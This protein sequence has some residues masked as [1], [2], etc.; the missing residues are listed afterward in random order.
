M[1]TIER[2]K[3]QQYG[4]ITDLDLPAVVSENRLFPCLVRCGNGRFTCPAQDVAHFVEMVD[5]S[6]DYVRDVSIL[7]RY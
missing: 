4:F 2:V 1:T 7:A 5:N 6:E 3:T